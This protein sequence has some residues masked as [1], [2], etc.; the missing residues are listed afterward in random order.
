MSISSFHI[1]IRK[2]C[3]KAIAM[4]PDKKCRDQVESTRE[5]GL[6]VT[7]FADLDLVYMCFIS[8]EDQRIVGS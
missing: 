7:C 3:L 4:V 2:Q 8:V 1:A 6:E 5:R